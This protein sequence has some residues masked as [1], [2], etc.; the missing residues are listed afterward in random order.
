MNEELVYN[1]YQRKLFSNKH[2]RGK[3]SKHY[4]SRD[5]NSEINIFSRL[6]SENKYKK[7]RSKG[8]IPNLVDNLLITN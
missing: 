8:D 2:P 1:I 6:V 4:S 3:Y 7:R 5:F